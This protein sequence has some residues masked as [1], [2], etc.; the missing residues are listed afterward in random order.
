MSD[1]G[2]VHIKSEAGVM[3]LIAVNRKHRMLTE[4][5]PHGNVEVPLETDSAEPGVVQRMSYL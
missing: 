3:S 2:V 4:Y 5:R 1:D